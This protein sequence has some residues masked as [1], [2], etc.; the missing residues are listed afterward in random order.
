M[1]MYLSTDLLVGFFIST[2]SDTVQW[3]GDLLDPWSCFPKIVMSNLIKNKTLL[4]FFPL[5]FSFNIFY[6]SS[7]LPTKTPRTGI[8]RVGSGQSVDRGQSIDRC[9]LFIILSIPRIQST[10]CSYATLWTV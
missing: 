10:A 9:D 8:S 5:S 3:S 6:F 4:E 7:A 2:I 1:Y